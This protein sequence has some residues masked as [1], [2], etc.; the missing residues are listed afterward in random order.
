M[1]TEY[2]QIKEDNSVT[3]TKLRP[4]L[5]SEVQANPYNPVYY[6]TEFLK[7]KSKSRKTAYHKHVVQVRLNNETLVE[8]NERINV[9]RI[10]ARQGLLY[11]RKK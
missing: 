7:G 6:W 2:F 8:F 5:E 3:K 10:Q 9:I 1:K 11:V 4:M